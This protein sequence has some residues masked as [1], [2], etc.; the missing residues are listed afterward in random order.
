MRSRKGSKKLEPIQE[1]C[2]HQSQD[3]SCRTPD[4]S[5]AYPAAAEAVLRSH[6]VLWERPWAAMTGISVP[7]ST[8]LLHRSPQ[9]SGLGTVVL[10]MHPASPVLS[11]SPATLSLQS[12]AFLA[13][14]SE[15]LGLQTFN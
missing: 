3:R 4:W 2:G 11:A 14:H 15:V 6:R 5:A 9:A 7:V 13:G 1:Q 12:C 10:G 8:A